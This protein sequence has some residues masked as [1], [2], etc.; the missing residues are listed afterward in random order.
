M[1]DLSKGPGSPES[2]PR[3]GVGKDEALQQRID[4]VVAGRFELA[5]EAVDDCAIRLIG[6][7]ELAQGLRVLRRHR[8]RTPEIP[9]VVIAA[10]DSDPVLVRDCWREQADDLVFESALEV[11]LIHTLERALARHSSRREQADDDAQLV[12]DYGRNTRDLGAALIRLRHNYD[13]TLSALVSALDLR[14]QETACHSQRVALYSTLMG[15]ELGIEGEEAE[16][17]Y[18][19]ALLHD[20]GKIGIPDAVLLKPGSFTDREREVMRQHTQMGRQILSKISFLAPAS[21]IPASHHE[22]WDGSGYPERLAGEDIPLHARI[23]AIVDAYDAIRSDRPYKK[24]LPHSE[25]ISRLEQGAGSHLDPE[26]VALFVSRP[27]SL[28]NQLAEL[29]S[30]SLSF[31]MALEGCHRARTE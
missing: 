28:W 5:L 19:G 14:E 2:L 17:L 3:L 31:Q 15:I 6:S 25:A 27:E 16:N 8:M 30:D 7:S 24:A 22:A 23:F 12:A 9:L 4:M 26:L 18:R 20:I 21:S 13:E 1:D 10:D 29:G 11:E